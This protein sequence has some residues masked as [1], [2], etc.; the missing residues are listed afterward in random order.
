MEADVFHHRTI[1]VPYCAM[2]VCLCVEQ[3]VDWCFVTVS[4]CLSAD[5]LV[6]RRMT[7]RYWSV[8][9]GALDLGFMALFGVL[10]YVIRRT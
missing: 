4:V 6:R 9:G 7:S 2:G 5:R 8:Q 3:F 1:G 10:Y